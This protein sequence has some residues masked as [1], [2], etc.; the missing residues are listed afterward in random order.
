MFSA[1]ENASKRYED[2]SVLIGE[3]IAHSP[4]EERTRQAIGRMNSLHSP[5]IQAGKISNQDLLYTL[6]VFITE[7]I[8]WI[9]GHEWRQLSDMEICAQ[10]TFWKSIGDAM[11]ITYSGYLK[12]NSWKDGIEFYEDIVE[13]ALQYEADHMVPAATNKQTANELFELLLYYVPRS[14]R[15]LPRQIIGVLMT[16]RL[17]AAMMYVT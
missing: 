2:T 16:E 9:N 10:G 3:F 15:Q 4:S 1:P 5:Y 7:P 8:S 13:W 11:N 12:R 14:L 17:R 6:S